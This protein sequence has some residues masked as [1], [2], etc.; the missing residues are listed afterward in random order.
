MVGEAAA[1]APPVSKELPRDGPARGESAYYRDTERAASELRE[2][3]WGEHPLKL[4]AGVRRAIAYALHDRSS[5]FQREVLLRVGASFKADHFE[6]VRVPQY[7]DERLVEATALVEARRREREAVLWRGYASDDPRYPGAEEPGVADA[8]A[9]ARAALA[10]KSERLVTPYDPQRRGPAR[11][12]PVG[13]PSSGRDEAFRPL[14]D[15]L[16]DVVDLQARREEQGGD[17]ASNA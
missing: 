7:W 3:L 5:D 6:H 14:R 1:L 9:R 2:Y 8:K 10:E 15:V 11:A 13:P 16:P 12:W 17:A 4:D